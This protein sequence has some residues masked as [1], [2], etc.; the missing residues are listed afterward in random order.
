MMFPESTSDDVPQAPAGFLPE[1]DGVANSF[2]DHDNESDPGLL[3]DQVLSSLLVDFEETFA[4]GLFLLGNCPEQV[5]PLD[6]QSD[7]KER[8]IEAQACLGA[9]RALRAASHS[10][11]ALDMGIIHPWHQ[12]VV[13]VWSLAAAMRAAGVTML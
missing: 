12:L 7:L 11:M 1:S 5:C 10:P 8:L 9:A 3:L 6:R 2:P 4:R 13:Q